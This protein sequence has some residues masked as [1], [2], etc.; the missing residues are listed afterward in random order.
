MQLGK[1]QVDEL[2]EFMEMLWIMSLK[3]GHVDIPLVGHHP[4]HAKNNSSPSRTEGGL[5][6]DQTVMDSIST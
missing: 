2:M 4:H 5:S 3:Q 1:A 6:P